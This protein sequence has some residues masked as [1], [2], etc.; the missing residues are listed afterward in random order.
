MSYGL[1]WLSSLAFSLLIV[2]TITAIATRCKK[3]L[4]RRFWPIFTAVLFF[5]PLMALAAAGM[6]LLIHNL[7]PRWLFWYGISQNAAYIIGII[8]IFKKG[9][10]GSAI[11]AQKSISWPRVRLT[12]AF[13][14]AL[15]IFFIVL[16]IMN[17]S[18]M[19]DLANIRTDTESKIRM[20]LPSS[21]PDRFNAYPIYEKAAEAFGPKDSL[22]KWFRES[23]QPDFD[24]SSLSVTQFLERNK[25]TQALL[26]NAASMPGFS[27]PVDVT[28]LFE[29][30]IS[31]SVVYL[32]F[33]YLLSLA[34]RS[35]CLAGDIKAALQDVADMKT[36][37]EHL[38][39]FP[40]LIYFMVSNAVEE[41]RVRALE[42]ILAYAPNVT[43]DLIKLPVMASPSLA[44]S[45]S[46][47]LGLGAQVDLQFFTK[48]AAARDV[49]KVIRRDWEYKHEY[50]A[51]HSSFLTKVWRV[52]FLPSDLR[53]AK[54]I[55]AD[56]QSRP[57]MSYEELE[58]N[59]K[60][61][62]DASREGKLGIFTGMS[63]SSNLMTVTRTKRFEA[64][65]GLSDLALAV[66][67]Y[68]TAKGTYP[69]SLEELTPEYI[70]RIPIDP[71]KG[72]PL[73]IK[74]IDSGLDLYSQGPGPESED[75]EK[76]PIHFY[77]GRNAYHKN[78]VKVA[79]DYPY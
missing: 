11:N 57:A 51:L 77:C 26:H 41:K 8:I 45:L 5:F 66:T 21:L 2:Y 63:V 39:H 3:P 42:Y 13:F 30:P 34:S 44:P 49:F 71:F 10:K 59:Y 65:R 35:K 64:L 20:L 75:S 25:N 23:E 31:D 19:I 78:R 37:A 17:I 53:A 6:L 46:T 9:L 7:Q 28:N 56:N 38:R 61:I 79:Q 50:T 15:F 55:I 22:P 24:M 29:V 18:V 12:A 27:Y 69:S 74:H 73:E 40:P 32:N 72:A 33:S 70:D 47:A 43:N 16:D 54:Y 36:M 76:G 68:R 4:W 48:I 52:F 58:K 14:M 1:L 62:Q 67:A 60:M